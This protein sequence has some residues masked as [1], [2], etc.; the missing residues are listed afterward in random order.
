MT[1][2]PLINSVELPAGT[3]AILKVIWDAT[4]LDFKKFKKKKIV[5]LDKVLKGEKKK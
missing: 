1:I 2:K 3:G 4:D 5:R